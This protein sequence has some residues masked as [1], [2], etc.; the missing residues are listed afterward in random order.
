MFD[1]IL[2][3]YIISTWEEGL[4]KI[5]ERKVVFNVD[6]IFEATGIPNIGKEVRHNSKV[7]K[8]EEVRKFKVGSFDLKPYRI[9]YYQ[10]SIP[11]PWYKV[12]KEIMKFITLD[13]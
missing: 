2:V 5:H 7:S 12:Y 4:Y 1:K 3:D 9:G 8:L 6:I 11:Y 13:G 10:S